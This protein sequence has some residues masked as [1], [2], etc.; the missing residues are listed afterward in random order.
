MDLGIGGRVAV[1][2][3]AGKGI[4]EA[5]AALL[6]EEGATVVDASRTT[7]IDVTAPDAADRIAAAA[8]AS[9][10]IL[11]NN[12]GT[13]FV[14]PLAELSD[15]DWQ[16]QWD[17]HVTAP[18]R[19]MEAFAPAMAERGWGRIVNVTSSSGKRPSLTNAAYSVSKAAQLSL[20]RVF[21]DAYAGT[22]VLVNAVAPG[23]VA[24]PLWLAPGGLAEQVAAST[25]KRPEEVLEAQAAKIP[26]GR[27]IEPGEIAAVIA[28]LCSERAGAVLGAAWSADGGS[29]PSIV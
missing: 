21:A 26:L 29:V 11:V 12:A 13:S 17:L 8:G 14:K 9:V 24:G 18:R 27:L 7:G 2:T 1:V 28:F 23:A 16:G 20:S 25:G 10:D 19:L 6:R 15:E 22:G 3:G 4:G 5:V